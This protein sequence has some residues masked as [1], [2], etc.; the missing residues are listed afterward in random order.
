MAF[1]GAVTSYTLDHTL[2]TIITDYFL[3]GPIWSWQHQRCYLLQISQFL[4]KSYKGSATS[5][6]FLNTKHHVQNR[7][8]MRGVVADEQHRIYQKKKWG[9]CVQQKLRKGLAAVSDLWLQQMIV[10][11]SLAN[12]APVAFNSSEPLLPRAQKC[13]HSVAAGPLRAR[14]I[15]VPKRKQVYLSQLL[16]RLEINRRKSSFCLFLKFTVSVNCFWPSS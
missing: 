4:W 8:Q 1:L 14:I 10:Q 13:M 2:E 12:W 11:G 5:L 7:Q 9:K 15:N 6:N 16:Y 3:K